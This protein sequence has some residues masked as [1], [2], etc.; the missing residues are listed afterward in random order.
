MGLFDSKFESAIH[1]VRLDVKDLEFLIEVGRKAQ[2][3]VTIWI[4]SIGCLEG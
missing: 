3:H 1:G 2:A 4:L